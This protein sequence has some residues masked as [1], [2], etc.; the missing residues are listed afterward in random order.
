M[1]CLKM[2]IEPGVNRGS[3][4]TEST[5]RVAWQMMGANST[6]ISTYTVCF[7]NGI[8]TQSTICT[9]SGC[10]SCCCQAGCD[11]Q[12]GPGSAGIL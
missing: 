1:Q 6:A 10:N 2:V 5:V 4:V 3:F 8:C 11:W 12:L 9:A 7:S